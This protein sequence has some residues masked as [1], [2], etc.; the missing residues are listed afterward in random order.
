MT[1][2]LDDDATLLAGIIQQDRASFTQLYNRY[3]KI[4]YAIAFKSFNSVEESEEIV[5]DVFAQV[6]RTARSY[7]PNRAKVNTWL[8]T[9]AR[10]R[11]IDRLR[12]HQR[13][14]KVQNATMIAEIQREKVSVDPLE[15]VAIEERRNVILDALARLP[16]EQREVIELA[17][18][19]GLSHSEI[20]TQT[21][22]SVGTVKSR[23]RLGL[24]KLRTI[25]ND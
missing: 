20:A 19:R 12:R 18:Y 23:V 22:L 6:W 16:R 4:I 9:I 13:S 2:P 14:Y 15:S 7:N 21:G 24:N 8:F 25:L 1:N 5:L 3:A 17:Y 11:I 10:S